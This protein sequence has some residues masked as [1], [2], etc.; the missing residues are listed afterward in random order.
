M[1][2]I[3]FEYSDNYSRGH[4][5]KQSCICNSTKEC[6][7]WYGLGV[8]CD[9]HFLRIFNIETGVLLYEVDSWNKD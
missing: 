4:Y 6:I 1:L 7:D 3:T 8:D 2:E 5:N 9:Y